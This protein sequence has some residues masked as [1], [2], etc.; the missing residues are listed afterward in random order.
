MNRETVC[1]RNEDSNRI[2][3]GIAIF[4]DEFYHSSQSYA[5]SS[6]SSSSFNKRHADKFCVAQASGN[7]MKN[8]II[9]D[10]FI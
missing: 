5:S 4:K 8:S 3:N 10:P 9:P 7:V 1:K 2:L 6:Q